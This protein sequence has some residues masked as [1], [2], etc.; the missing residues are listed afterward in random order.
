MVAAAE[1]GHIIRMAIISKFSSTPLIH[2]PMM[3]FRP[4]YSSAAKRTGAVANP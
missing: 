3:L 4:G 2:T 1:E